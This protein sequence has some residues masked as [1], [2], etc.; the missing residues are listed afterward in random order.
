LFC[1]CNL[2]DG[3]ERHS[4]A[5][6]IHGS[7]SASG[8]ECSTSRA[9]SFRDPT[10]SSIN[11]KPVQCAHPVAGGERTRDT[12]T[13]DHAII[14]CDHTIID[15]DHTYYISVL[16]GDCTGK[17]TT[18]REWD[19]LTGARRGSAANASELR[20]R[21]RGRTRPSSTPDYTSSLCDHTIGS[22]EWK[23]AKRGTRVGAGRKW[24]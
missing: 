8:H 10:A 21:C 2:S 11:A 4:A 7:P 12:K 20:D 23:P 14:D 18:I 22:S 1:H 24:S 6:A 19:W 3:S 16:D 9:S 5:V 17:H 15:C 13:G